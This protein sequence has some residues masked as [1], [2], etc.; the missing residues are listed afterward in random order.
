MKFTC[1]TTVAIISFLVS[2]PAQAAVKYSITDLGAN[3]AT[4]FH[5]RSVND[6]GQVAGWTQTGVYHHALIIESDGTQRDIGTL[7]GLSDSL[8]T[9]INNAGQVVGAGKNSSSNGQQAFVYSASGGMQMLGSFGRAWCVG[10]GI[11]DKGQI[12]GGIENQGY[13]DPFLYSS[14][15]GMQDLGNLGGSNNSWA[16]A[17]NNNGQVVGEAITPSGNR[18][19][20]LYTSGLPMQ[21]LGTLS[22]W[23]YSNSGAADINDYGQIV[24]TSDEFHAFLYNPG[25][26]MKDIGSLFTG[27]ITHAYAINNNGLVVGTS[28][29]GSAHAFLYTSDG[30]MQDLNT[31]IDQTNGW[32]LSEAVAI[33]ENGKIVGSGLFGGVAHNFLLTPV[34]EPSTIALLLTATLG[35]LLWWRRRR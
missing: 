18:H 20:F 33:S 2:N 10:N 26:P 23:L 35:G 25:G 12:V 34:P 16:T 28:S 30:G 31:L 5:V 19:A 7:G 4:N 15:S 3:S 14:S 21:D 13:E 29:G 1:I 9:G 32:T 27:G 22:G 11:N 17:I 24:G 8:A 6:S